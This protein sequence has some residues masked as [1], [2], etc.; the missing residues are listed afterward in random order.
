MIRVIIVVR[1]KFEFRAM[2]VQ[3]RRKTNTN[4]LIEAKQSCTMKAA[5][6]YENGFQYKIEASI[7]FATETRSIIMC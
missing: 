3:L 1:K 7:L 6:V 2:L 5:V 4:Q